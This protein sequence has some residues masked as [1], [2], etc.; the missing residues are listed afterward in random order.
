MDQAL[1][2]RLIRLAE[3]D[4]AHARAVFEASQR[5]PPHRGR[6]VFDIRRDE[7][8]PEYFAAEESA[9]GRVAAFKQ[10]VSEHGWPG[11]AVVGE[12]GCRCAWLLAQHAG[13]DRTFQQE[14]ERLL[15]AA[16]AQGD[17]K[18]GQLAALRDRLELH[19]GGVQLYGTHLE[20]DGESWRPVRG[21]DDPD[22]VDRRR[23]EL[24]LKPWR[25]YLADC[26]NGIVET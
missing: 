25:D 21:V 10:I 19:R 13:A 26:M 8:L 9:V 15:A 16:V 4:Q 12:D 11:E 14:C 5:H 7:W 23:L 6:F 18:P 17:A 3:D 1:R 24:G 20:P 2:E 22:E